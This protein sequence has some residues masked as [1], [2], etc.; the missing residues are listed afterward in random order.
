MTEKTSGA[1]GFGLKLMENETFVNWR[2]GR[3]K[4]GC[5]LMTILKEKSV[6]KWKFIF[7]L[8]DFFLQYSNKIIIMLGI[9][10]R[11]AVKFNVN[12]Y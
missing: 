7:L 10:H 3:C 1:A 4:Y 12:Q 6:K 8:F 2:I 5:D 9:M 11:V